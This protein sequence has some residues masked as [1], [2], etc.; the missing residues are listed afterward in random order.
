MSI[1]FSKFS[2]KLATKQQNKFEFVEK[3]LIFQ[4]NLF[5]QLFS[6]L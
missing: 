3:S 5:V 6:I 4:K 1:D 2:K